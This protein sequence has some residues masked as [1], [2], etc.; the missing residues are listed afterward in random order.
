MQLQRG[1]LALH[2]IED[3]GVVMGTQANKDVLAQSGLLVQ[4][5][6]AA[7]ADD[8][9]IAVRGADASSAEAA[10]E[11]V[12]ALLAQKAQHT[13][14]FRPRSIETAAH[15]HPAARWLLVSVPGRFGAHVARQ[16]LDLGR[17]VFLYSDNVSLDDEIALKHTA[18]ERG[19]L[20]MGPDWSARR[21]RAC[22]W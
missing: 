9:V 5:A 11:Q 18:A 16:G 21:V 3:A 7:G 15:M 10:L 12:D 2:G 17:H 13:S 20:V 14:D 4:A 8:L 6:Q 19:L 22:S 1:L